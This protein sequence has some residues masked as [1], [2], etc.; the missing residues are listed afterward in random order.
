[1]L[2][3]FNKRSFHVA[4]MAI[5]LWGSAAGTV[6]ADP[7]AEFL[8]WDAMGNQAGKAAKG[9]ADYR[10]ERQL[11]QDKI[12]EAKKEMEE[13][14]GCASARQKL[15]KWQGVENT[16][17]EFAAGV[18]QSV[19]MPPIV[20]QWL[21]IPT[22]G[23]PPARRLPDARI[24]LPTWLASRPEYCQTV[25]R[26]YV[27]CMREFQ[28]GRRARGQTTSKYGMESAT[29]PGE[30][31]FDVSELYNYCAVEDYEGYKAELAV[32]NARANGQI[33]PKVV[34]DPGQGSLTQ[35]I[36]YGKVPDE[37]I[38][39]MP[40]AKAVREGVLGEG[41]TYSFIMVKNNLGN[42]NNF[43]IKHL[44]RGDVAPFKTEYCLN[45]PSD[46]MAIE[47]RRVCDDL[48]NMSYDKDDNVILYC[49]YE[50][51]GGGGGNEF[52][53]WYQSRPAD[54]EIKELLARSPTHPIAQIGD[55]RVSC[56]ATR[57][58]A[59]ELSQRYQAKV[60]AA[61]QKE[62]SPLP[63]PGEKE[64]SALP[65]PGEDET[66]VFEQEHES[67][68]DPSR[69]D[70]DS[71]TVAAPEGEALPLTAETMDLLAVKFVPDSISDETYRQMM[72]ARWEYEASIPPDKGQPQWGRFF[73]PA[74]PRPTEEQQAKLLLRFK[75][76]TVK[77]AEALP[78]KTRLHFDS[79]RI[80]HVEAIPVLA[81]GTY[82]PGNQ[83][84]Y[85]AIIMQCRADARSY[86][87]V[88]PACDYLQ[89]I[90]THSP[91]I[92]PFGVG[93][94]MSG[95]R[96][97]C[98]AALG[99]GP[100]ET[101][102]EA[103]KA[104]FK[105]LSTTE[106]EPG[107]REILVFDKEIFFP[108][109]QSDAA[110]LASGRSDMIVDVAITGG[111]VAEKPLPAPF[112][113]ALKKYGAFRESLGLGGLHRTA[114]KD[115]AARAYLIFD[116]D[117]LSA[118]LV[119][120]KTQEPI[121][122]LELKTARAPDLEALKLPDASLASTS[123]PFGPEIAGVRLG[124]TFDQA[125]KV[126]R[127]HMKVGE[128][129]VR[130]RARQPEA[131]T[132]ALEKFSSSKIYVAEDRSEFI[133]LYDEPP[134]SP[135]V[136]LAITRQ[137]N[138]PKGQMTA[139]AALDQVRAKYGKETWTGQYSGIG[140]G[141]GLLQTTFEDTLQHSCLPMRGNRAPQEWLRE[142]G[143]PA[144]WSPTSSK[145]AIDNAVP[146]MTLHKPVKGRNCGPILAMEYSTVP[147]PDQ[148]DRLILQLTDP[149]LYM[150]HYEESKR[151]VKSGE[152]TFAD[153]SAGPQIKF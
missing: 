88:A 80:N 71:E 65:V 45:T 148:E 27:S 5:A 32:Q 147:Y 114:V 11:W 106:I 2:W 153:Q 143:T 137:L 141:E 66:V 149:N 103:R 48:H 70:A 90:L 125:D 56:P 150:K 93:M 52:K 28:A 38:P 92:Y 36:Y 91:A 79:A 29:V 14:G 18:F 39:N 7:V 42:L 19:G 35:T 9:L 58:E 133:M 138:L 6:R 134:S 12:A 62:V 8:F 108:G 76:W 78:H 101:Y 17:N 146:N 82:E 24:E 104:Q 86:P 142:D 68:L 49:F 15:E 44:W 115:P 109:T 144:D 85:P 16:F 98:R 20:G 119:K 75:E 112:E 30:K 121:A 113:E 124:M 10:R 81:L 13:C 55:P 53:Y 34:N 95:P 100:R 61:I 110:T 77:R 54:A 3:V 21:G 94:Q 59:Q 47:G 87:A 74:K 120:P 127:S 140:W 145:L 136:V 135:G 33:I 41:K 46:E 118:R 84:E 152:G 26:E 97:M 128:V 73:V 23:M 72:L 130:D 31:C 132:G 57:S 131:A 107:F 43:W 22:T 96:L 51:R 60:A 151:L 99:F 102:C 122:D 40:P 63:V 25:A 83:K 105:K 69:P 4:S 89:S 117:V 37:Y 67:A 64:V 129:L 1:M 50:P 111:H 116:A 123:E 139:A 126:I